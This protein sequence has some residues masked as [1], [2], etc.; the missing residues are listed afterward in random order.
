MYSKTQEIRTVRRSSTELQIPAR[1][2]SPA[3]VET[4]ATLLRGK[5]VDKKIGASRSSRYAKQDP[6]NAGY[7]P[8]FPVPVRIGPN[9]VRYIESEIDAY[10]AALPRTRNRE[11]ASK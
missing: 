9:S 8:A 11:G 2:G 6:K 1:Q 3:N 10:I 5:E 4:K 7:D